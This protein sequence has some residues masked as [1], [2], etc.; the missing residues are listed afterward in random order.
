MALVDNSFINNWTFLYFNLLKSLKGINKQEIINKLLYQKHY[1]TY[2]NVISLQFLTFLFAYKLYVTEKRT[3]V[4]FFEIPFL[5]IVL[6]SITFDKLPWPC[7]LLLP[8]ES[9]EIQSQS[10]IWSKVWSRHFPSTEPEMKGVFFEY[11]I[12]KNYQE[13]VQ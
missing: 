8:W 7:W 2:F 1:F 9:S 11:F 4:N 10:V 3:Y 13:L 6:L 5:L 12:F